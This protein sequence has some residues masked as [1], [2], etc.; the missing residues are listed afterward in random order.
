MLRAGAVAAPASIGVG[1]GFTLEGA[2]AVSADETLDRRAVLEP[3]SGLVDKYLVDTE[4][5]GDDIRF[6]MLE[7]IR[8]YAAE[9]LDEAGEVE[10]TRARHLS[11]C[12]ELAERAEPEFVR[13]DAGASL[14]RLEP[15]SANLRAALDWAVTADG[16]AALRLAASLTFFWLLQGRLEEGTAALVRVLEVAPESTAT[17]GRVLWGLAE[18][19]TRRG[20]YEDCLGY[21]ERALDGGEAAGDLSVMA[22]ALK[23]KAQIESIAD[24]FRGRS[25]LERSV[26]LAREAGDKWCLADATR[27]LAATYVRQGEHDVARPILEDCYAQARALGYRPLHAAYFNLRAYGELEHGRVRSARELAEQGAREIAEAQTIGLSTALLIECDVLEGAPSDGRARAEPYLERMREAGIGPSQVWAQSALVLADVAEGSLEVAR[28]RVG[29]MLRAVA[30]GG[31]SYHMEAKL[32]RR[33]AV[34]LLLSTDIDGAEGEAR[35]LLGHAKSGR[36]EYL[37]ATAHHL[38]GRVALE[39]GKRS[40]PRSTCTT[41]SPSPRGATSACRRSTAWNRSPGSPLSPAARPKRRACWPPCGP[42][43]SSRGSCG[44]R[45]SPR[46]GHESRRTCGRSSAT[47][48]SRPPGKRELRWGSTRPSA[49]PLAPAASARDPCTD[50][51][52]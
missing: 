34:V 4:E 23:A 17:R 20:V 49:T 25:A 39:R 42:R 33:L 52:A 51:R 48:R 40:R 29:E 45:R 41:R 24:H 22:R 27:L 9:R 15:E 46:S 8:Q 2:E 12:L 26:E 36:N 35:W 30:A 3:L 32:R 44:G 13:H 11:W 18:L 50:G 6:R 19:S 7:T 38:L 21:A 5:R 14:R 16:E 28:A 1:G 37:E 10:A 31:P 43:G 47:M